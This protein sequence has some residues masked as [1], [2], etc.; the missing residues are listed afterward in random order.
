MATDE[1]SDTIVVRGDNKL[2]PSHNHL[3][4]H[5]RSVLSGG[6]AALGQDPEGAPEL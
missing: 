5:V 1:L 6:P 3:N 4:H 2:L